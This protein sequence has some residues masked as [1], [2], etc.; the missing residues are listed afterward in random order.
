[1]RTCGP[2]SKPP[3]ETPPR[4]APDILLGDFNL[5]ESPIDRLPMHG[6]DKGATDALRSL[7]AT[8]HMSD[9]WRKENP[10]ER[11]YTF[12]QSS[13]M[14]QSRIDRIYIKRELESKTSGWDILGPGIPTDHRMPVMAIAN[15]RTPHV[16]KGRWAM[17]TALLTDQLFLDKATALGRA[18]M[19]SIS[20][21]EDRTPNDNPQKD[22]ERFK[23]DLVA[24]AR[25][26]AK[27]RIPKLEKNIRKTKD[28]LKRTLEREDIT[29]DRSAQEQALHLQ[30]RIARLE[31]QRFGRT[32]TQV[33]ARE[34]LEGET[35][36]KYWMR[37]NAPTKPDKVIYEMEDL[38]EPEDGPIRYTNKSSRMA[39]VAK[40]F[41]N[42]LQEDPE[43]NEN[44]RR[45]ATRVVLEGV[46]ARLSD[47]EY[48]ALDER[49]DTDEIEE[50]LM[51]AATGKSPGLDGIPAELWKELLKKQKRDMAKDRPTFDITSAMK[52]VFNDIEVY[53][54]EPDTD[55]NKGWICPI[56]KKKDKRQI[57]NYRPIT[58]L[59]AD[60]K[61]MTRVLA[62]RLAMVAATLIH[63]DQAGFIPGRQIFHHIKLTKLLIN[64]AEASEM[65]GC[66]VALDQEKAYDK[67]NHDYLWE[68][69]R[70]MGFPASFIR[71]IKGL[72]ADAQSVVIVN[73]ETSEA[74][75]VVRGVRQGDPMSCLLFNLAIEP[76]AC[77]LRNSNLIGFEIASL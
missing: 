56:Y 65:N 73:G 43:A 14:S 63:P 42:A 51:E 32:R 64:Q 54:V 40:D 39:E 75:R 1:M 69:L 48:D 6:D 29:T 62:T 8:G 37:Q 59:N 77:A 45:R 25:A 53:G 2:P 34:W 9:G 3:G 52:E 49:I 58:L 66:I 27:E 21:R 50:A 12:T 61:V 5:I 35:V 47:R 24:A 55:F 57:G 13:T 11:D 22:Y 31:I 46:D 33:A 18:L 76:L 23:L 41:Y 26:R 71:T 70:H 17:P 60:Y 38:T 36:S 7:L 44:E 4:G 74:F 10:A 72:Y 30:E 28:D 15:Y 20:N 68:V 67:I 19:E 16:G